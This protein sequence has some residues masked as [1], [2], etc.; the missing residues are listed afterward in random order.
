MT[1]IPYFG[2]DDCLALDNG[3][4]R[5]VLG[6]SGGRLLEYA[7]Q[8]VNALMLDESQAGWRHGPGAERVEPCGGRCDIG[9]E[10]VIPR[11]P[12]LWFG[13]WEAMPT[14]TRT[15]RL[16]SVEDE[17][18]G[19][20]LLRD[21]ELAESGSHLRLTQTIRNVSDRTVDTCHWSRTFAHGHGIVVMPVAEPSR[22]PRQYVMYGPGGIDFRPDDPNIRVADG[23]LTVVGPP[24]RAK[25][26]MESTAGWFAYLMRNGLML[27]KRFPVYP[28]RVY[29]EVAGLTVSIWYNG[30]DVCEL[31]PIGPRELLAP[32]Q[33]A[34]FTEEWWLLEQPFPEDPSAV[35]VAAVAARVEAE[36]HAPGG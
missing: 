28:E 22:F 8:G 14:G 7:W 10:Q 15:A 1:A 25:L 27:V 24:E 3:D 36:T 11:H 35:D 18:T 17:A 32:G 34:S 5:V 31:E 6:T 19:V 9:P 2:Y 21:V 29:N 23:F 20:Q 16:V 26:G 12:D 13:D 4:A 33:A 30:T